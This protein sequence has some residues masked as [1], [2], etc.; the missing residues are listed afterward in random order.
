MPLSY[1]DS[2]RALIGALISGS[3][4]TQEWVASEVQVT[5]FTD[6]EHQRAYKAIQSILD[7]GLEVSQVSVK[8]RGRLKTTTVQGFVDASLGIVGGQLKT[9]IRDI[10]TASQLR[11]MAS[12]F[13][14][15]L[16][17]CNGGEEPGNVLERVESSLYGL[18]GSSA[19]KASDAA[20]IARKAAGIF[21]DKL[22]GKAPPAIS[23][24]LRLLDRAIIGWLRGKL[25]IIGARPSVGK[26]ALA[27]TAGYSVM[28]Q[29]HGVLTFTGE[30]TEEDYLNRALAYYSKVNVRKIISGQGLGP[31]EAA[32]VMD[33]AN[34]IPADRWR[35]I[36]RIMPIGTL[37]RVARIEAAKM[38]RKNIR[39]GLVVVDYAQLYAD[40]ENREQAVS[41]VSGGC[42]RMAKELDC[43]VLLLSQLNRGLEHRENKRPQMS[44]L[45]ESGALEQDADAIGF[46]YREHVY[47]RSAP[48]E[49]TELIIGKNRDGSTGTL[50]IRFHPSTCSFHDASTVAALAGG[51]NGTVTALEDNHAAKEPYLGASAGLP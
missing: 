11:G 51:V 30:M 26:S 41:A 9:L 8:D 21:L 3:K 5:D 19:Y 44:D 29:D 37:R 48:E 34:K 18:G 36:D 6:L 13:T 2:E 35:I 14:D 42:K 33:A 50:P 24:G 45:R 31:G 43:S 4:D 28:E 1:V 17:L 23:T 32:Q 46:L 38:R 22:D 27:A 40:G 47:D 39:L 15:A 16:S 7:E 49:E 25:Y 12:T 20:D 10:R